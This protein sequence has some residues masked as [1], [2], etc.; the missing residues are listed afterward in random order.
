M[1]PSS[2]MWFTG[3]MAG[4]AWWVK[5]I[6]PMGTPASSRRHSC[7]DNWFNLRAVIVSVIL[8]CRLSHGIASLKP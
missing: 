1:S 7:L 2:T 3:R 6:R 4:S 8:P 5:T